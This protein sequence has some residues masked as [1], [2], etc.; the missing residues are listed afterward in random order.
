MLVLFSLLLDFAWAHDPIQVAVVQ[1]FCSIPFSPLVVPSPP[2]NDFAWVGAA[3]PLFEAE[4]YSLIR[5]KKAAWAQSTAAMSTITSGSLDVICGVTTATFQLPHD[6][7]TFKLMG[8][9]AFECMDYT[10][11]RG[12]NPQGNWGDCNSTFDLYP[13]ALNQG[14]WSTPLANMSRPSWPVND[15]TNTHQG[16]FFFLP[17]FKPIPSS[18]Q[19]G[20]AAL[21]AAADKGPMDL[22]LFTK[23]SRFLDDNFSAGAWI[24]PS[25]S[26]CAGSIDVYFNLSTSAV[27]VNVAPGNSWAEYDCFSRD[28]CPIVF[29]RKL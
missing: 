10:N 7:D 3:S 17:S 20:L 12:H 2:L 13:M 11:F 19:D 5:P 26:S 22:A 28:C 18:L 23:L 21:M 29:R 4:H 27:T 24:T 6:F 9:S 16:S 1:L 25:S 14:N 8:A 15:P